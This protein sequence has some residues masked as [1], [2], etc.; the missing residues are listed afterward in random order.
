V[1]RYL[2]CRLEPTFLPIRRSSKNFTAHISLP[3]IF[4]RRSPTLP[5]FRSQSRRKDCQ[6][7]DSGI[8]PIIP[9]IPMPFFTKDCDGSTS[10]LGMSWRSSHLLHPSD[11]V[12]DDDE[13]PLWHDLI[14]HYRDVEGTMRVHL[15]GRRSPWTELY[16]SHATNHGHS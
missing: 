5:D 13:N 7:S 6:R 14:R 16:V 11:P 4:F 12:L 15:Q 1:K 3:E 9:S 10:D 2:F 8:W